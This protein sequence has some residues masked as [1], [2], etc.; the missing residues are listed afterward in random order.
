MDNFNKILN[1]KI[2]LNIFKILFD[3]YSCI[4]CILKF[5]L[6]D[7]YDIYRDKILYFELLH[8]ISEKLNL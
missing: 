5:F 2:G 8:N 7:R 3:N 4:R 6:I 1:S